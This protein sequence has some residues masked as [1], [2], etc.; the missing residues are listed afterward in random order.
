M[1]Y[2][3]SEWHTTRSQA[4]TMQVK[5]ND[6]S[7][8]AQAIT[9]IYTQSTHTVASDHRDLCKSWEWKPLATDSDDHD[10]YWCYTVP[11]SVYV[12]LPQPVCW[13]LP[14]VLIL[15]CHHETLAT[16][17]AKHIPQW[18]SKHLWMCAFVCLYSEVQKSPSATILFFF[19]FF[20]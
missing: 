10:Q 8:G 19:L 11:R 5:S 12:L 4:I 20:F 18:Q 3:L 2:I 1:L 6:W 7:R 15:S 14:S 17:W 13:L 16:V 9:R